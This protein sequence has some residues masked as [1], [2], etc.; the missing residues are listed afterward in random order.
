MAAGPVARRFDYDALRVLAVLTLLVYHGTRPFD[1]EAWHVKNVDVSRG[2]QLFGNALTPWRLPLLFLISGAGTFFALRTRTPSVYLRDRM[3]RLLLPLAVGM[4]VVVPPQ[5]Y[6][7]RV[8]AWMP[9]RLSPLNFDGS[10]LAFLPHAFEGGPYP[11]GNV[12]WHHLWFFLYLFVYSLVALPLFLWL[13]GERGKAATAAIVGWLTPGPRLF[14]LALPLCAVHVALQGRFPLTNAL[15]GDWWVLTH[16]FL[17]FVFG[18]VLLPDPRVSDAAARL[19]RVAL[20][21]TIVFLA[22]RLWLIATYGSA[23]PYS[24]RYVLALTVRGLTEWFAL[25]TVLGYAR[26]YLDRPRAWVAWAGDRVPPFYIWHQTVLVVIGVWIIGWSAG[27]PAKFVTLVLISLAVTV[28][29]CEVAGR[30]K[31]TRLAF[32]MRPRS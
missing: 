13:R 32:G 26:R 11:Q 24:G 5:V 30:T 19:R 18:Y 4:A 22:L 10:F 17:V 28:G 20:A 3:K 29:L 15:V 2:L 16:Y 12:S 27:I 9:N 7:E 31:V 23:T 25:V 8:N 1:F 6:V 21:A 14:L